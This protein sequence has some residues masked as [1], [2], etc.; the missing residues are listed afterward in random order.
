MGLGAA[1][2]REGHDLFSF[3]TDFPHEVSSAKV[4][5]HEIDELKEGDDLTAADKEAVLGLNAERL[6]HVG[7]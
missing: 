3:V 4:C 2:Q 5:R 6:Y 7:A 1:V